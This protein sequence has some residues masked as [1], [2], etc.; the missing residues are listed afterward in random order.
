[1]N[2]RPEELAF[3]DWLEHPVTRA[4]QAFLGREQERLKNAWAGGAFTDMGQFGTAILNAKAIGQCETLEM[5][6]TL[7]A[8]DVY[9]VE[10]E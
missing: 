5:L 10:Q 2:E 9:P 4:F 7:E 3:K 6:K 1:M 8:E